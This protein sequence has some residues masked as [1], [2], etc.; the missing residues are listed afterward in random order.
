M[1]EQFDVYIDTKKKLKNHCELRQLRTL[2][3]KGEHES[4]KYCLVTPARQKFI[5]PILMDYN[6]AHKSKTLQL[7]YTHASVRLWWRNQADSAIA[8]DLLFR[9]WGQL[10]LFNP[11]KVH[12]NILQDKAPQREGGGVGVETHATTCLSTLLETLYF[13]FISPSH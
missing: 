7:Y 4:V 9:F 6:P 3:S 8:M 5:F 13:G 1:R 11:Q 10:F 12:N 2:P